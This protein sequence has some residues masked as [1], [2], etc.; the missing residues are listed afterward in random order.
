MG[1]QVSKSDEEKKRERERFDSHFHVWNRTKAG[2]VSEALQ[3]GNGREYKRTVSDLH[4][5]DEVEALSESD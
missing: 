4:V 3:T 1:D 2:R 5:V